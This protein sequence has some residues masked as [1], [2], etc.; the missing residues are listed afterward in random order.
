MGRNSRGGYSRT[1]NLI[2]KSVSSARKIK[3]SLLERV[4]PLLKGQVI[5]TPLWYEAMK[6]HPPPP[7]TTW[8]KKPRLLQFP[9]DRLKRVWLRDYADRLPKDFGYDGPEQPPIA[10]GLTDLQK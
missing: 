3:L 10:I 5:A 6:A 8:T 2:P 1:I 9:E 4:E 7:K